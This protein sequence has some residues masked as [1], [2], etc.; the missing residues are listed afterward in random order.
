MSLRDAS[1]ELRDSVFRVNQR[2]PAKPRFKRIRAG[3]TASRQVSP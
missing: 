2:D 1:R 3:E